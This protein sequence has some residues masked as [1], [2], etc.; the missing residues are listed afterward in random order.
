M[1]LFFLLY[2]LMY[3]TQFDRKTGL[4]D[5]EDIDDGVMS[6]KEFRDLVNSKEFGLPCL[7]AVALVAD[8]KS[9]IKYYDD[10][11]RPKKAMEEVTG[12]RKAWEWNLEIIQVALKKYDALQYDPVLEE[13]R[14][15]FDQKVK[16]L[17]EIQAYDNLPKDDPRRQVTRMSDLKKN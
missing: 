13:G 15:Y 10:N 3:L 17:K 8:Y 2:S 4:L 14:I 11:D 12:Q 16:K 1:L 5:I 7:T 9:P 6:I